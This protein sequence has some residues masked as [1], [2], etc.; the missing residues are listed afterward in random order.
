MYVC[1]YFVHHHWVRLCSSFA[2]GYS[3]YWESVCGT[4]MLK[5]L[6]KH[7]AS[8]HKIKK[9]C[10]HDSSLIL[11][12]LKIWELW[13][14]CNVCACVWVSESL[15]MTEE[16]R[17][18]SC[19]QLLF[20]YLFLKEP[21]TLP[22]RATDRPHSGTKTQHCTL[23]LNLWLLYFLPPNNFSWET[24]LNQTLFYSIWLPERQKQRKTTANHHQNWF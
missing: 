15:S 22:C 5:S 9:A 21:R 1:I 17:M 16:A 24:L 6:M 8:S 23:K 4:L 13:S 18:S 2:A 10:Q 19:A 20:T 3:K 11:Y 12:S 7:S 14:L